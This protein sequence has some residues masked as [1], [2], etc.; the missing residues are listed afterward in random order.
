MNNQQV[1]GLKGEALAVKYLKKQGYKIIARNYKCPIGEIDIIAKHKG[2]LV[3]IE[4]KSRNS[5]AFGRPV[6]AVDEF[7]QRK[8]EQLASFYINTNKLYDVFARFDVVEVLGDQINLIQ[9]AWTL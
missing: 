6:E 3:F 1:Y 8:L 5:L 2:V 7:K 4:V 9:N